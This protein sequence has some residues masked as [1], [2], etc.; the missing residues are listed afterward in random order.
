MEM[1]RFPGGGF[2]SGD[3]AKDLYFGVT[4][5]IIVITIGIYKNYL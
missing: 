4:C 5:I 3:R 2:Q 1:L